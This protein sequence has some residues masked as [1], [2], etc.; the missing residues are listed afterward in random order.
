ML[1]GARQPGDARDRQDHDEQCGKLDEAAQTHVV[2]G[3]PGQGHTP[4]DQI[5][6][7]IAGDVLSHL[8]L[9]AQLDVVDDAQRDCRDRRGGNL[10]P[11]EHEAEERGGGDGQKKK[12]QNDVGMEEPQRRGQGQVGLIVDPEKPDDRVPMLVE[13]GRLEVDTE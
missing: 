4:P 1:C 6:N 8:V 3:H 9:R 2:P 11:A 5:A 13:Q 10:V 12:V 7:D